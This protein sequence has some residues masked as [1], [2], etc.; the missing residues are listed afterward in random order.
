MQDVLLMFS[1][2]CLSPYVDIAR[3]EA[4]ARRFQVG[5]GRGLLEDAVQERGECGLELP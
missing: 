3:A 4:V 5:R 1:V 2:M